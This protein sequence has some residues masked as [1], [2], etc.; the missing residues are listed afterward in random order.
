MELISKYDGAV[1][2]VDILGMTALTNSKIALSNDDY[3]YW[4]DKHGKEYTDQY[5][6]ASILA[7]FRQILI[8]L[9]ISFQSVTVSQ[10]SDC[11]FIWSKNISNVVLFAS[12]FMTTAINRGLLCR[13]GMTYGEIIE[14]NQNHQLGR[15]I[16]GKAV[17]DAAKLEGIAKGA[18]ILIDKDFPR[19]LWTQ[20]KDFAE[21]T[22]PLF[23]P[24]TNPLDYTDYDEFKWYLC[25]NLSD[26]VQNLSILS[27]A[28]RV[29][30]TKSRLK[31]ANQIRF[32]PKFSWNSKSMEGVIQLKATIN[33]ISENNLLDISHNFAWTD[34]V[35]KRGEDVVAS[36][37]RK[38]D[39]YK[40]YR[41]IEKQEEPEWEE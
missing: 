7:E 15:F 8:E 17:T 23:A 14:T 29:T 25:P 12:K 13:G 28:E 4:L 18:R 37:N 27:K 21:R 38:I 16:V 39:S 35:E 9:N 41:L 40:D 20:N 24:F 34:V 32:S 6:A 31:I 26:E 3:S 22:I 33:F 11:A 10:L 36:A 2:F 30:L 1:F 19:S 5:L